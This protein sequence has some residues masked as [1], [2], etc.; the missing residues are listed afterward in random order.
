MVSVHFGAD[1]REVQ[2]RFIKRSPDYHAM[3]LFQPAKPEDVRGVRHA[4]A[5]DEREVEL[6]EE[7]FY[8]AKV[9][10]FQHSVGGDVGIDDDAGAGRLRVEGEL[11]GFHSRRFRPAPRGDDAVFRVD[12]DGDFFS[13]KF[14]R[15]IRDEA[16]GFRGP[17]ADDD[18]RHAGVEREPDGVF[19]SHPAAEFAGDGNGGCYV[20]D[21]F[22]IMGEAAEGGVQVDEVQVI[23]A[24]R[25]PPFCDGD[26]V[27]RIYRFLGG[28]ALAE[29]DDLASHQVDG[30]Q[31]DHY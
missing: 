24:L 23:A 9:R 30:G 17:R 10:A 25:F 28:L 21:V 18:A 22:E 31:E 2:G 29:A 8:L 3:Q 27:I 26:R 5:R 13:A 6:P 14:S 11:R 7:G 20:A 1:F 19:A 15:H 4:A 12:A 16:D